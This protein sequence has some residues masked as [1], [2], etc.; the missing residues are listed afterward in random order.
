[1]MGAVVFV[2][3]IAI[4]GAAAAA[5]AEELRVCRRMHCL[6]LRSR[7]D[8]SVMPNP[9]CGSPHDCASWSTWN[10]T[11]QGAARAQSNYHEP[12]L[13]SPGE[14]SLRQYRPRTN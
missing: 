2:A 7:V 9:R 12:T 6:V 8:V 4:V 11:R 14:Q 3:A 5:A 10:H 13:H 1:M